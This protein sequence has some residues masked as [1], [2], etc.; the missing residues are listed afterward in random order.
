M[1]TL[2]HREQSWLQF[3]GPLGGGGGMY[4]P[5]LNF[6]YSH[7]IFWGV[8]HVTVWVCVNFTLKGPYHRGPENLTNQRLDSG[9]LTVKSFMLWN[10]KIEFQGLSRDCQH[11][12]EWYCNQLKNK[13]LTTLFFFAP[14]DRKPFWL[15][16]FRW[17]RYPALYTFQHLLDKSS[18]MLLKFSFINAFQTIWLTLLLW[19]KVFKCYADRGNVPLKKFSSWLQCKLS[20]PTF[21]KSRILHTTWINYL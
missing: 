18:N 6:K 7:L 21:L 14:L 15:F 17:P 10:A 2:Y 1:C 20:P 3:R 11:I 16:L 13:F 4:V 9:V 5:C 8:G 12:F 19:L